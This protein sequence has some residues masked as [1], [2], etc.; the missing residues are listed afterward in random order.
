MEWKNKGDFPVCTVCPLGECVYAERPVFGSYLNEK[1]W[2]DPTLVAHHQGV[3]PPKQD[4]AE[5]DP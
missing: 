3:S 2:Y 4:G 5:L 1:V